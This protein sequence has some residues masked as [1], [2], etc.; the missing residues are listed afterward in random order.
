MYFS[1]RI[2]FEREPSDRRTIVRRIDPNNTGLC[3]PARCEDPG[4]FLQPNPRHAPSDQIPYIVVFDSD[5]ASVSDPTVV[6]GQ[7]IYSIAALGLPE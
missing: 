1:V 3:E 2:R 6:E 4:A 5:T 7:A